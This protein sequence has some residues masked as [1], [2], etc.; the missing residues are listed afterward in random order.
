MTVKSQTLNVGVIPCFWKDLGFPLEG[1]NSLYWYLCCFKVVYTSLFVG[2]VPDFSDNLIETSD[3]AQNT[4]LFLEFQRVYRLFRST[5]GVSLFC[6]CQ[7]LYP[8]SSLSRQFTSPV[9]MLLPINQ[10]VKPNVFST[11]ISWLIL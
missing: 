11:T 3:S 10:R 8:F 5:R 1:H 6:Y 7:W 9:L 4:Q 2:E